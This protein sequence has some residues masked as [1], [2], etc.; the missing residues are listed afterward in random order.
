MKS[1]RSLFV[2]L[3]IVCGCASAPKIDYHTLAMQRSG[4]VT[5]DHNLTVER[6]QTSEAL[7]R[8]QILISSSPTTVEYYATDHWAG[9]VGELVQRKLSEE[10]GP[11]VEGRRNLIV[12]GKVLSFEQV[13]RATGTA[14][15]VKLDVVVRDAEKKR[16]QPPVLETTYE[17]IRDSDGRQP[18]AVVETLSHCVEEIAL[19][20]VDDLKG[21]P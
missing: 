12:S 9:G 7:G 10:F 11:G 6:F 18:G 3:V 2:P 21:L 5:P 13:D 1:W 19:E 8:R 14:A 17:V 15:R 4:R 20:I 16:Y